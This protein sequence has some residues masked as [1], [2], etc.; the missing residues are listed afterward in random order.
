MN[1]D[2]EQLD[3]GNPVEYGSHTGSLECLIHY[4]RDMSTV[5]TALNEG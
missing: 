5:V 3:E 2:V 4:N 1:L